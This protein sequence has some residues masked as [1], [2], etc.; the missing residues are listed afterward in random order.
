MA[1]AAMTLREHLDELR[2]RLI[3]VV[4]F[5]AVGVIVAIVFRNQVLAFLL[6]PGFGELGQKPIATEVLETVGVIMKVAFMAGLVGALPVI[7]YQLIR[8]VSPGLSRRER[9]YLYLFLP[10]VLAA[11]GAGAAFA[12]YVLF[13]PAFR[14]LFTFGA[15]NVDATIRISS[16]INVVISLMF[17]MGIVFQL[18]LVMF[19]LARLG[20]VNVR[21]LSRFRKFAIVLAFVAAAI[22]TPTF[23]P[24]NQT[25][26]AVPIIV[27]YELGILLARLGQRLRRGKPKLA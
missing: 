21:M 13:P 27:L 4:A 18:P 24:V 5:L 23:D 10:G 1:S 26:V 19:T 9:V 7:L 25:L 22:I 8:F 12:Y 20:V 16:Y 3:I 15:E 14:F 11:F 6:E 2:R 17:W